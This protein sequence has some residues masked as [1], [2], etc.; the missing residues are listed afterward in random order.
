MSRSANGQITISFDG[1]TMHAAIADKL[2][3]YM[4]SRL[5]KS[6]SPRRT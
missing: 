1:R 3:N 6:R 4:A 5:A 2:K